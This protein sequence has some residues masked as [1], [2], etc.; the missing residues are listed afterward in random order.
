MLQVLLLLL[1][2]RVRARQLWEPQAWGLKSH[3]QQLQ[4]AEMHENVKTAAFRKS[5]SCPPGLGQQRWSGRAPET[6]AWL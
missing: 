4:P 2:R 5:W 3:P 1:G 6:E